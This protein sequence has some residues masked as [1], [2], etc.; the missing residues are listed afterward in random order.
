M[1][2]RY[3]SDTLLS[4]SDPYYGK[5]SRGR[6]WWVVPALH[7]FVASPRQYG[8]PAKMNVAPV[9]IGVLAPTNDTDNSPHRYAV[10]AV[11]L[12][13]A[14]ETACSLPSGGRLVSCS[15]VEFPDLPSGTSQ[16]GVI[17]QRRR[18]PLFGL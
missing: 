14:P 3:G 13:F 6:A 7:W 16:V 2:P 5:S 4:P 1:N 8:L 10:R 18:T 12:F 17:H 11:R 15:S 9:M